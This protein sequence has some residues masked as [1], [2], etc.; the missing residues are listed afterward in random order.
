M[1]PYL[2]VQLYL[3]I[4]MFFREGL[5]I[6]NLLRMVRLHLRHRRVEHRFASRADFIVCFRVGS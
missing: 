5:E 3:P 6:L 4:E 2:F 1:G